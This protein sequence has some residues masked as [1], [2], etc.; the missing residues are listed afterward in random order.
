MHRSAN[1]IYHMCTTLRVATEVRAKHLR[2]CGATMANY[3][4]GQL[5]IDALPAREPV[6][7]RQCAWKCPV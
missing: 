3:C 2:A 5:L 6:R 1:D 7:V 4:A